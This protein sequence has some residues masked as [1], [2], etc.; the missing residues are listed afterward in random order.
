MDHVGTDAPSDGPDPVGHAHE[1]AGVARRDVQMVDVEARDREAAES[2]PDGERR[3]ALYVGIGEGH[4]QEERSLH[5]EAAA[6]EELADL[7]G[8]KKSLLTETVGEDAAAGDDDGH[9][10]VGQRTQEA[11]LTK[12]KKFVDVVGVK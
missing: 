1:D 11:I 10:E 12:N 2:H 3:H 4:D 6:V 5:S 7:G 8:V 9:Q